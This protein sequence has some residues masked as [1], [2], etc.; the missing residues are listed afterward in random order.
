MADMISLSNEIDRILEKT[1]AENLTDWCFF[2]VKVSFLN[3]INKKSIVNLL[4]LWYN[5]VEK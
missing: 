5:F 2:G 3:V 1:P 4:L